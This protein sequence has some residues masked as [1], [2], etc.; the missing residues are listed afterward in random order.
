MQAIF[1]FPRSL[2]PLWLL[3][4]LLVLVV[5]CQGPGTRDA[6]PP[7][8]PAPERG[9]PQSGQDAS[10]AW[11]GRFAEPPSGSEIDLVPSPGSSSPREGASQPDD[12]GAAADER[13]YRSS[14]AERAAPWA[15]RQAAS[16]TRGSAGRPAH[17]PVQP[18]PEQRPGLATQW[19]ET[20]YSPADEVRFERA[21]VQ[22]PVA[23]ERLEYNDRQGALGL[24][25]HGHWDQSEIHTAG[26]GLSV[27]M[28]NSAGRSFNA[29]RHGDRVVAM[30]EPGERYSLVIE[31]RTS[32]RFEIVVSV[33][34]LDVLDG[35]A[36]SPHKRGYLVSAHSAIEVDGFRRSNREVAAFRLGDVRQ[37]YAASKGAARNVGVI[38]I[39]LFDEHRPVAYQPWHDEAFQRER[40]LRE[41]ADPF[42]GRY[43]QPPGWR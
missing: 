31:N 8:Y 35:E 43:A 28:I 5:G 21:D 12:T 25:P 26:G 34:G 37:S 22:R 38:G 27:R 2:F 10:S 7:D 4:L 42:P 23:T 30:G 36:A 29:L 9:E 13:S 11:N 15:R 3:L 20:R 19:G 32:E 24:L 39:A 41:T 1:R 18:R 16:P 14:D 33:D 17:R 6:P 40:S